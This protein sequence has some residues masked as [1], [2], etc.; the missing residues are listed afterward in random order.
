ME[1]NE[2][3]DV[4]MLGSGQAANPLSS[5]FVK[6]GK[7]VALIERALG[8]AEWKRRRAADW[9]RVDCN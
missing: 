7:R 8:K 3:F 9:G 1:I 6:A 4:V 2:Q 5:A